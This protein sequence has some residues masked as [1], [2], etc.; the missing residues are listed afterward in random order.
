MGG[1]VQDC[2][3]RSLKLLAHIS[4]DQKTETRQEI[5]LV[6]KP[7]DIWTPA[8]QVAHYYSVDPNSQRF[9]NLQNRA[10]NWGQSIKRHDSE[11]DIS[12][13]NHNA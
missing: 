11:E 13:L 2:E 8:P 10:T 5:G 3:S 4:M 1:M 6:Y 7:Q 12:H 9:K